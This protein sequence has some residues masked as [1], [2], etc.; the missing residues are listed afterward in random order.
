MTE[1]FAR[2]SYAFNKPRFS[3]KTTGKNEHAENQPFA[4][5][6]S[7]QG[8]SQFLSKNP[9]VYSAARERAEIGTAADDNFILF[10]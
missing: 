10:N 1:L 8:F 2:P 6:W 4:N 9:I 5:I 3:A 7:V